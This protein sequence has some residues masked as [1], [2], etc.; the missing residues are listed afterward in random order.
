MHNSALQGEVPARLFSDLDPI[1]GCAFCGRPRPLE[2]CGT[3]MCQRCKRMSLFQVLQ[4][5][6]KKR[7]EEAA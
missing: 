1:A 7:R 5:F 3:W 6:W 2:I 4:L